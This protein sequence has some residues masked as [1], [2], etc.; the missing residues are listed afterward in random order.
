M[1]AN[2]IASTTSIESIPLPCY[3]VFRIPCFVFRV[4]DCGIAGYVDLLCAMSAS[5]GKDCL[6]CQEER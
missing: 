5:P 1:T 2:S 4:H 3:S 6:P